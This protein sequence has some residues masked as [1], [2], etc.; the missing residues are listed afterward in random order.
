MFSFISL[1]WRLFGKIILLGAFGDWA[2]RREPLLGVFKKSHFR[3]NSKANARS[4]TKK[5]GNAYLINRNAENLPQEFPPISRRAGDTPVLQKGSNSLLIPLL[6][7]IVVFLL[8]VLNKFSIQ[9]IS[10]ASILSRRKTRTSLFRVSRF[11]KSATTAPI[12]KG[13]SRKT[14]KSGTALES[15]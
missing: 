12:C 8:S 11:F 2:F 10:K 9:R 15:K 1:F 3:G 7:I 14:E 13:F 5:N 6:S 4:W